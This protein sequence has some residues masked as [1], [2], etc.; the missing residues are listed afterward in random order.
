MVHVDDRRVCNTFVAAY[1]PL[2]PRKSPFVMAAMRKRRFLKTGPVL[3]CLGTAT[4]IFWGGYYYSIAAALTP[5]Q[6]VKLGLITIL[7]GNYADFGKASSLAAE[8]AVA[9]YNEANPDK[10]VTLV[11]E[12]DGADPKKGMSAFR[13]LRDADKAD[14]IVPL[15]TFTIGTV[16]D[17][18]NNERRVTFILGNEPYEPAD[19]F[20]YM[21]SP[22]AVPAQRAFG[23]HVA[24]RHPNGNIVVI[25]SQNEALLRFSRGVVS[26]V[27]ARAQ[28]IEIPP[29]ESDLR[30]IALRVK[31]AV[32]TAI[33]FNSLPAQSAQ[34]LVSL[35]SIGVNSKLYFDE[36]LTNSLSDFAAVLGDLSFLNAAE[37]LRMRSNRD[38]KFVERFESNYKIPA[39]Q[40]A[41]FTY[42]A[43]RLALLL[44]GMKPD[45]AKAW[46]QRETYDGVSGRIKFDGNGLRVS[47]YTILS[48]EQD[49]EFQR[50]L[51]RQDF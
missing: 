23:A 31:A 4:L 48:L 17:L 14:I 34:M 10:K 51:A 39:P 29:A 16:R 42:D 13:K 18:V 32:P 41:D 40:A 35:R 33:V 44:H 50:F 46:L 36:S 24:E 11:V 19:D 6:P 20:V 22:A 1:N 49:Q 26:G 12:D 30:S 37:L 21:V 15:S 43:V 47:E 45:E 5:I 38:S 7:S 2:D 8:L 28:L 3:S 9:D 25:T 27:G